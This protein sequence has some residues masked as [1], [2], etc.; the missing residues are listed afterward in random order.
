MNDPSGREQP[1]SRWAFLFAHQDGIGYDEIVAEVRDLSATQRS[2]YDA[3]H[4]V[5]KLAVEPLDHQRRRAHRRD[6]MA[7]IFGRVVELNRTLPC[8]RPQLPPLSRE[9]DDIIN[10]I[11]QGLTEPHLADLALGLGSPPSTT[12]KPLILREV[13]PPSGRRICKL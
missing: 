4:G 2:P 5:L 9:A 12:L 7:K 3:L 6:L 10:D 8:P 13:C 1:T 11:I